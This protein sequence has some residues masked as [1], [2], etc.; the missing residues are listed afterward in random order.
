MEAPC[1][2]C[3]AT[4]SYYLILRGAVSM[5]P[6]QGLWEAIAAELQTDSGSRILRLRYNTIL[7]TKKNVAALC[8]KQI[9]EFNIGKRLLDN[10]REK[11]PETFTE[12]IIDRAIAYFSPPSVL[13][14][15]QA[16]KIMKYTEKT[17]PAPPSKR[18]AKQ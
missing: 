7:K 13:F 16:R 4:V 1:V 8:E 17:S 14:E 6:R 12:D 15:Q 10:R 18:R 9:E 5:V 11:D 3:G 2:C